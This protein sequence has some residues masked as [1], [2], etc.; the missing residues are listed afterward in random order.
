MVRTK[1]LGA[2][3]TSGGAAALGGWVAVDLSD[4]GTTVWRGNAHD[5]GADS[6]HFRCTGVLTPRQGSD[7]VPMIFYTA[8]Y[9]AGTFLPGPRDFKWTDSP[10]KRSLVAEHFDD[11]AEG[12]LTTSTPYSSTLTDFGDFVGFVLGITL[13]FIGGSGGV[14]LSTAKKKGY[15]GQ[16][17]GTDTNGMGNSKTLASV[18]SN[19]LTFSGPEN[20][21]AYTSASQS[22]KAGT[23]LRQ[24]PQ[25]EY[26]WANNVVFLGTL[27]PRSML[28]LTDTIG[29]RQMIFSPQKS[30]VWSY[31]FTSIHKQGNLKIFLN[32]GS[33][34]YQDPRSHENSHNY[35]RMFIKLL[36]HAW[37][38]W[39]LLSSTGEAVISEQLIHNQ[40][41]EVQML[42]KSYSDAGPAW[43]T[44]SLQGQ[45]EMVADWY[46]GT[47]PLVPVFPRYAPRSSQNPF[48]RYIRDNIREGRAP[49]PAPAPAPAP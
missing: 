27:P 30:Q 28:F 8:G 36:T 14:A 12:T 24:L 34:Q 19:M 15:L 29:E 48:Y 13:A 2:S 16:V 47:N 10:V 3:I 39:H 26:D 1:S 18:H 32:M 38:V 17:E 5:G 43:S 33:D 45:A 46:T 37:Q 49:L 23:Q 9:V 31:Q 22:A 4:D 25:E 21:L 44:Y 41:K 42:E 11:F 35:G 7:Q 6:Y 40:F 20:T